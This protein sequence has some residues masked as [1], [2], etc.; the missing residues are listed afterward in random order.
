MRC[1]GAALGLEVGL[2]GRGRFLENKK[3]P[4]E[5]HAHRPYLDR[6]LAIPR[7]LFA[8]YDD[9]KQ[10]GNFIT[11]RTA[12][13]LPKIAQHICRSPRKS[14]HRQKSRSIW[15]LTGLPAF[16]EGE[17]EV[18]SHAKAPCSPDERSDI[19]GRIINFPDIASRI[20]ATKLVV[21]NTNAL[22]GEPTQYLLNY[23]R[24]KLV[25]W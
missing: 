23:L 21:D 13:A 18:Y 14:S 4:E 8:G 22:L 9:D 17:F 20:R 7:A 12:Q 11:H 15:S 6:L 25:R 10:F 19:R 1:S 2:A 5:A 24:S 16:G 3:G